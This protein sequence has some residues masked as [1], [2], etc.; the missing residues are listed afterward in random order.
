MCSLHGK[1]HFF[2]ILLW[3]LFLLFIQSKEAKRNCFMITPES[4]ESQ[5]SGG[6]CAAIV[7]N[8]ASFDTVP[9]QALCS[10]TGL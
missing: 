2:D 7:Q 10:R 4:P 5:S 1:N 8:P 3:L 6:S 9:S